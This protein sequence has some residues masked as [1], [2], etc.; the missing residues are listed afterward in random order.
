MKE[1]ARVT[2]VVL[3]FAQPALASDTPVTVLRGFPSLKLMETGEA[4]TRIP[5]NPGEGPAHACV[6]TKVGDRYFWTSR[7]NKELIRSVSGVFVTFQAVDGS[8]YVRYTVSHLGIGTEPKYDYV[9]HVTHWL[10]GFTYYGHLDRSVPTL[11]AEA[12]V[13]EK[14]ARQ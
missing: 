6:V 4:Q 3:A 13:W 2:L 7:D 5:L 14:K 10:T 11:K 8:G 9:E 1:L 12:A